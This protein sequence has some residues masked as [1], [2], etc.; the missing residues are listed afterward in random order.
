[1]DY[2]SALKSPSPMTMCPSSLSCPSLVMHK[3]TAMAN[4]RF[5]RN[6]FTPSTWQH[7]PTS[8]KEVRPGAGEALPDQLSRVEPSKNTGRRI[9]T[10]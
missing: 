9:V 3:N 1:M 5:N 2:A 10:V 7:Y 4:T 8:V 6:S